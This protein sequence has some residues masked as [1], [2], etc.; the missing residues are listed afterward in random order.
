MPA[1]AVDV[2][3]WIAGIGIPWKSRSQFYFLAGF[4]MAKAAQLDIPIRW[5]GDWDSDFNV[6]DQ[7]FDDLVHFE[8]K[9]SRS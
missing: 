3:P 5:G 2:A 6:L 8:K 4:V 1:E 9:R 7:S